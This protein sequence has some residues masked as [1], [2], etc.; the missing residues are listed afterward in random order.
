[1][2]DTAIVAKDVNKGAGLMA[3]RDWV[4]GPEA[5]TIAV[6]DTEADLPMFDVATH[7]FAPA[8]IACTRQ[9]QLLGCQISRH[10]YQRGLLDIAQK[11]VGSHG[12]QRRRPAE[13]ISA[14]PSRDLLFLELL[15]AADRTNFNTLIGTLFDPATFKMF[16]H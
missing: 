4:L 13:N 8:H 11:F 1:M 7:S 14:V 15:Q 12:G 9:A 16:V 5:E 2:N 10:P 6:G 3:L